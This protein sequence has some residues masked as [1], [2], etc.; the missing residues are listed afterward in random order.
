MSVGANDGKYVGDTVVGTGAYVGDLLCVSFI[1]IRMC[2][3][4]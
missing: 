3:S 2:T 1:F 4:V